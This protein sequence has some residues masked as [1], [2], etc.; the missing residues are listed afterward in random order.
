[1]AV[2]NVDNYIGLGEMAEYLG[3]KPVT[4][5]SWVNDPMN[6]IPVHKIGRL[7]K[8]KRSE[9]DEWVSSGESAIN[10]STKK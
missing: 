5:R 9:I 8:F 7:W 3:V 6:S 10:E 4:L 1:M 2:A